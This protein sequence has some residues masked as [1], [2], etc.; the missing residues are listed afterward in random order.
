MREWAEYMKMDNENPVKLSFIVT[1]IE[2]DFADLLRLIESYKALVNRSETELIIEAK[3]FSQENE[4]QLGRLLQNVQQVRWFVNPG[5]SRCCRKD[6]GMMHARADYLAYVDAD[7]VI[8]KDYYLEICKMLGKHKVIRGKNVYQA[9][10][11]YLSQSNKVYRTLCDEVV[12]R[13]ETF[14]PNLVIQKEFLKKNG[15]WETDNTDSGDDYTLSQ[16]LKQRDKFTI[17]HCNKAIM[18]IK[19]SGDERWE[20]I[21]KTWKGYG[22]AYQVRRRNAG[23]CNLRSFFR[24]I[25]P[26]VYRGTAPISYFP[27]AVVNWVVLFLG[28]CEQI[29][30]ERRKG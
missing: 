24:Y 20:K 30:T 21:Y 17:V 6:L 10:N 4:E 7:C 1:V 5:T 22:K 23:K 19:N 2:R 11:N 18:K 3:S 12:F 25:P 28:Y 15:G 29:I 26:F 8:Q 16:R 27:M 14:T 9:E 13:N